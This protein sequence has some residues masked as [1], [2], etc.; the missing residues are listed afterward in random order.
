[1]LSKHTWRDYTYHNNLDGTAS[2]K[3]YFRE[4]RNEEILKSVNNM[5]ENKSCCIL[6]IGHNNR[7]LNFLSTS[8]LKYLDFSLVDF[9]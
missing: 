4:N 9:S 5:L 2:Y 7:F 8:I 6:Y 1:L 3:F